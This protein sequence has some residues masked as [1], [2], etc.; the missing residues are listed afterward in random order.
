[1]GKAVYCFNDAGILTA[2]RY[3]NG[4]LVRLQHVVVKAP[5]HT[6]FVPYS[7]PTPLPS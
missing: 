3:P 5:Q 7:S 6:A 2:I 4:N 1:M